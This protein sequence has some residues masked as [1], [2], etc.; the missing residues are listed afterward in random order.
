M[1]YH[2]TDLHR[3]L[4]LAPSFAAPA[5][6]FGVGRHVVAALLAVLLLFG[7]LGGWAATTSLNGAVMAAGAVAVDIAE[8]G[9]VRPA[10]GAEAAPPEAERAHTLVRKQAARRRIVLP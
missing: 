8:E 10:G 3:E 9:A 2:A 5:R 4:D 1:S 7:L 6:S